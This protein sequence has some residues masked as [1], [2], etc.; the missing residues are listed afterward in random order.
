MRLFHDYYNKAIDC[1]LAPEVQNQKEC[2]QP[3]FLFFLVGFHLIQQK[4]GI[5]AHIK[6]EE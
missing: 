2:F 3:L 1:H 6:A 5:Y 4:T